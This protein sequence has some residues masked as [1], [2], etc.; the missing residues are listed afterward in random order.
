VKLHWPTIA[1]EL[2]PASQLKDTERTPRADLQ[3]R[4][5][6]VGTGNPFLMTGHAVKKTDHDR[7]LQKLQ[8]TSASDKNYNPFLK[9]LILR[10]SAIN[11]LVNAGLGSPN[12]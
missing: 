4:V 8:T 7:T 2:D 9:R 3:D 11:I 5:A 12:R 6:R 1:L 10:A